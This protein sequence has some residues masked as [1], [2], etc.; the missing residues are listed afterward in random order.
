MNLKSKFSIKYLFRLLKLLFYY[1]LQK[2]LWSIL[3]NR[4][5]NSFYCSGKLSNCKIKI[6]GENNQ[7]I[8]GQCHINNVV[9]NITGKN[10]KLVIEKGTIFVEGGRIRIEDSNNSLII[11]ENNIVINAFFSLADK[12]T[13]ITLGKNCLISSNV[14]FRTSDSHS[15]IDLENNQRINPGKSIDIGQHVWIGN[16]VTVLKGV[17]IQHD[18]II[19][20]QS[21]VTKDIPN[22]SIAVGFPAKVVKQNVTWDT[23]R[24]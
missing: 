22:N 16:G 17:T 21:M 15:I 20:T 12:D 23:N 7:L 6:A 13:S 8:I 11:K 2:P 1:G 9:I 10:N 19:G 18:S 4:N 3:Y 24:I 14:T 5:G